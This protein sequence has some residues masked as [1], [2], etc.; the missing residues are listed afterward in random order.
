MPGGRR[1]SR[2]MSSPTVT[3]TPPIL[4]LEQGDHLTRDEFERRYDAMPGLK[5]AE[6]I[7]GVVHMP[8]PVRWS[9]HASPHVHISGWIAY[10]E[11]ATPGTQGGDNASIRL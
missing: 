11:A 8:S 4:P 10:Y 3:P 1:R 9:R 5:K 7:D 2:P 6:L